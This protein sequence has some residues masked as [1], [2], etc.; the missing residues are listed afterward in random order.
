MS[1]KSALVFALTT[2]ASLCACVSTTPQLDARFGYAVT[3]AKSLQTLNPQ[4]SRNTDPVI[5]MDGTPARTG[6]ERYHKSFEEPPRTFEVIT[7]NGR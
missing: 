1:H 5:G 6:V 3:S 2:S 4:A 7:G